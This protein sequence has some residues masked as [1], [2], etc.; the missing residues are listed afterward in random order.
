MD[1]PA[2]PQQL[3]LANILDSEVNEELYAAAEA[4]HAQAAEGWDE[5]EGTSAKEGF[6]IECEGGVHSLVLVK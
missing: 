3:S 6:C 2:Q 4:Q 1:A 5:E